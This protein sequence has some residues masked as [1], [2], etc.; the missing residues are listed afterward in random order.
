[1]VYDCRLELEPFLTEAAARHMTPE[2]LERIKSIAGRFVEAVDAGASGA[3]LGKLDAEFHFEI[4]EGSETQL[5]DIVRSYRSK[6]QLQLST[7]VYGEEHPVQFAGEHAEI[8]DA[9]GR[10][11]GRDA[12][13]VMVKHLQHGKELLDRSFRRAESA[14]DGA[15]Q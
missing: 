8:V 13:R 1:M 5:K 6:L 14:T 9:L 7:R 2:R 12:R 11:D 10:G 15:T 3:E 4:Y